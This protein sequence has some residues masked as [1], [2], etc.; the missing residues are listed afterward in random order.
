[1]S[2]NDPL[3]SKGHLRPLAIAD[4]D[5]ALRL[6][7]EGTA[8]ETGDRFFEALVKNLAIVL[9]TR[10]AWVTEYHEETR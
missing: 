7:V 9:H 4:E 2:H 6:I 8:T 10:S 1:M 5:A 3:A